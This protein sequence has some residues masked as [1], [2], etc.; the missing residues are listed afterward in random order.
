MLVPELPNDGRSYD[1]CVIGSGPVGITVALECE[2]A[3]LTVLLLE[4]GQMQSQAK[5]NGLC[6]AEI[7]DP[8]HHAPLDL[9]TRSGLGGT[10]AVWGG[11]C[12]PFD[13]VDF[14]KRSFVPHSGW[15]ISHQEVKLWYRKASYYLDCGTGEF[16]QPIALWGRR[17]DILFEAT[18]RLSTHPRMARRFKHKLKTSR[19]I[20][21]ALNCPI[22]SLELDADGRAVRT[23]R[24]VGER[25]EENQPIA[26]VFVLACGGLQATG[27]LLDLQRTRPQYFGSDSGPLGRFY[28]GHLTGRIAILFSVTP[29][30]S[31]I[32]IM[33][34]IRRAI[35]P[36]VGSLLQLQLKPNMSF[37]TRLSG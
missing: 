12:V 20:T 21:V 4:A 8:S 27:I 23:A 3:G 1:V 5:V 35:G 22:S 14:E 2:A 17:E 24:L 28:M 31:N 19:R 36:G 11:R 32:L 33:Y 26:S 37:S 34:A 18:E 13:D 7:V 25:L 10:S 6:E 16:V 9:V 15:P 30:T 29:Q